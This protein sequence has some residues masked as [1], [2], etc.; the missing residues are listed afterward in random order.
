[1][2]RAAFLTLALIA[3][4]FVGGCADKPWLMEKTSLETRPIALVEGR[5]IAKKPVAAVTDDDIY[6]A[7]DAYARTGAGPLY[8]VVAHSE[9][10]AKGAKP[11]D[12]VTTLKKKLEEFGVDPRDIVASTVPLSTGTPVALVAF[13]TLEAQAPEGCKDIPGLKDAAAKPSDFDY[14]LGCSVKGYMAKQIAY[15]EDLMGVA[16]LGGENDGEHAAN[17]ING[18]LRSGDSRPFL[19]SYVI[20]ALAGSGG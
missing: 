1:M 2:K 16:G 13:D 18:N 12:S 10:E 14:K 17:V 9:A 20:S 11:Q 4:T 7:V 8:V 6:S 15:P 3:T 19:P 5:Y